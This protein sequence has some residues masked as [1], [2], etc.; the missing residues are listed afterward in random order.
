MPVF[1][2]QAAKTS[3][4]HGTFQKKLAG[5]VRIRFTAMTGSVRDARAM[6]I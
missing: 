5:D 3:L 2:A 4:D 1:L 6:D